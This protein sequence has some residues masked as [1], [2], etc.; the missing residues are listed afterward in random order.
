MDDRR[1]PADSGQNEGEGSRTAARSYN[2]KTERF[3]KSGKVEE[4][5]REAQ[6]ALD[7]REGEALNR[8][9]AVGKSKAR[10]DPDQ[11]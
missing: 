4:K 2:R 5:A 11:K 8:A 9:E 6:E 3:A 1:K 10:P 7:G